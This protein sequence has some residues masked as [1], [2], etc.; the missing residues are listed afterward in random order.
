MA[1]LMFL[2]KFD[3]SKPIFSCSCRY[4]TK[5][6]APIRGLQ[7]TLDGLTRNKTLRMTSK[8]TSKL[9]NW[10]KGAEMS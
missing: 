4:D 8:R 7:L 2:E 3:N 9:E 6:A 1:A 10:G 5:A